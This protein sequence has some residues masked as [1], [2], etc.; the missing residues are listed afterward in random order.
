MAACQASGVAVSIFGKYEPY[1]LF[2]LSV[3]PRRC[4]TSVERDTGIGFKFHIWGKA[5][6]MGW[7]VYTALDWTGLTV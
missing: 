7:S 1:N 3:V 2:E 6:T 5:V 4:T